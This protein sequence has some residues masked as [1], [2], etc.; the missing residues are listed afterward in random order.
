MGQREYRQP[1]IRITL[2]QAQDISSNICQHSDVTTFAFGKKTEQ[3]DIHPTSLTCPQGIVYRYPQNNILRNVQGGWKDLRT[4]QDLNETIERR[5]PSGVSA[6]YIDDGSG[7]LVMLYDTRNNNP[8]ND[9]IPDQQD[10]DVALLRYDI[11]D[12]ST[13]HMNE[14][15]TMVIIVRSKIE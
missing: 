7:F 2:G 8:S 3:N 1:G 5:D 14:R 10:W 15:T 13:I 9:Q 6:V 4:Y 11:P 12:L